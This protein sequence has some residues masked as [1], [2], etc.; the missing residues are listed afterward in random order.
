MRLRV[1]N[2]AWRLF[3]AFLIEQN[4][5]LAQRHGFDKGLVDFGAG[6]LVDYASLL[7]EIIE[8]TK[9][10]QARLDCVEEVAHARTILSRGTS[11]HNQRRVYAEAKAA[12]ATEQ[13]AL[14]KVVDWLIEETVRDI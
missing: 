12:G 2:K 1:E 8:L 5:W 11:A 3:P 9:E 6:K 13:E 14:E 7:E 4:R 10:D